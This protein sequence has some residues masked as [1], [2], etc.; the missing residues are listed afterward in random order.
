MPGIAR[1]PVVS[2]YAELVTLHPDKFT[3]HASLNSGIVISTARVHNLEITDR[4]DGRWSRFSVTNRQGE[5]G[6]FELRVV[7]FISIRGPAGKTEEQPVVRMRICLGKLDKTTEVHLVDQ[8]GLGSA[9]ILGR[10]F[11]Q[12]DVLVDSGKRF[13]TVPDCDTPQNKMR[14]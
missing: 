3:V 6:S 8:E 10:S 14:R 5:T 4:A 13:V 7:R 9:V 11:M 2:G 12:S 1:E